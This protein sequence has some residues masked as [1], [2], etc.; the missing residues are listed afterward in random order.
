MAILS[1]DTNALR[2]RL[3]NAFEPWVTLHT[4]KEARGKVIPS[5]VGM[6]SGQAGPR[7]LPPL[8]KI[9]F[10]CC[11]YSRH[12]LI[13]PPSCPF[14]LANPSS[15]FGALDKHFLHHGSHLGLSESG[16]NTPKAGNLSAKSMCHWYLL[17]LNAAKVYKTDRCKGYTHL[18]HVVQGEALTGP[19][20]P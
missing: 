11:P 15:H 10:H 7:L 20:A 17:L 16:V 6:Y 12:P 8:A 1:L 19:L 9:Y 2:I 18:N 5:P 14:N 13:A 3:N 4:P